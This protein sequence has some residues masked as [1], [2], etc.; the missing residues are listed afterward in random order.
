MLFL[1]SLLFGSVIP[2]F[3]LTFV[4]NNYCFLYFYNSNGHT[5]ED[6]GIMPIEEVLSE[7][8]D[9]ITLIYIFIIRIKCEKNRY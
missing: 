9:S 1:L 6:I 3:C 5:L 7:P 2:T 8:D 4:I